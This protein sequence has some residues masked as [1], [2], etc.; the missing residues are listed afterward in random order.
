MDN[1]TSWIKT[2]AKMLWLFAFVVLL[3]I[4]PL[5]LIIMKG[6]NAPVT[7]TNNNTRRYLAPPT[8]TPTPL[9]LNAG[10]SFEPKTEFG[11]TQF[12]LT[13]TV[14]VIIVGDSSQKNVTG[15]DIVLAYDPTVVS[16]VSV[17]SVDAHFKVIAIPGPKK[18]VFTAVRNL[19]SAAS[20]LLGDRPLLKVAFKPLRKGSVVFAV[21]KKDGSDVTEIVDGTSKVEATKVSAKTVEIL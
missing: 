12:A 1:N 10:Y 17:Q 16:F 19:G 7:T 14:S 15:F 6:K 20:P 2:H 4:V 3:G 8:P 21:V 9:P 5:I 13:D 11:K 18:I